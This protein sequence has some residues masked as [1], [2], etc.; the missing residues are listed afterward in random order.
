MRNIKFVRLEEADST[1]DYLRRH[2]KENVEKSIC[3][4]IAEKQT[5]GRGAGTNTW[6]SEPGKNLTFSILIH[7]NHIKPSEQFLI[8]MAIS[9]AITR[10][11]SHL[12]WHQNAQLPCRVKWPNDV[13]VGDK[14]ICGILIENTLSNNLIKDCIIGVGLNVNQTEFVSD[15]PNPASLKQFLGYELDKEDVLTHLLDNF[16]RQ[17]INI[18]HGQ[19][20]SVREE[21][22]DNLYRKDGFYKYK[23]KDGEFEAKIER[24]DD[25]GHLV[26]CDTAG[27]LRRYGF[28][29]VEFVM[30][31]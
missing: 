24:I 5:A 1:N 4:A 17:M 31:K 6:E 29:E 14:K 2:I 13:Y 23:D 8:S 11:V 16:E 12:Q 9:N 26:L 22:A 15:A 27:N 21:Y 10:M 28:K 18:D 20:M 25:D 19:E 3:V 30:R 7:P